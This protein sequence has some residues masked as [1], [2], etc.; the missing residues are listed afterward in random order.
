MILRNDQLILEFFHHPELDPQ[1]SWFSCCLRLDDLDGFYARCLAAEIGESEKGHPRL[2]APTMQ[3][4][5]SRMGA[6][7]DPD[8]TL[9]RL[10]QN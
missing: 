6:L 2:H 1:S 10:I 8:G 5:G 9:V 7:I 4:W 3:A